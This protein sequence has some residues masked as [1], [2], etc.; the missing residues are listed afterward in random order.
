MPPNPDTRVHTSGSLNAGAMK[1][2]NPAKVKDNATA[3]PTQE[4]HHL[5]GTAPQSV[6]E[7]AQL[8]TGEHPQRTRAVHSHDSSS[9]VAVRPPTT[10][11]KTS[12]SGRPAPTSASVPA[13][14]I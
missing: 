3:T 8:E 12:S 4:Q 11:T 10:S 1:I 5:P 2:A 13:R 6:G 9:P 7:Q 14:L